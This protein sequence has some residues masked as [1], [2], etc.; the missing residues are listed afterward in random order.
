MSGCVKEGDLTAVKIYAVRTDVLSDTAGLGSG[1]V[2]VT[3]SV[4]QRRFTVV[5]V[6]H[7]ANDRAARTKI[8]GRI[9]GIV[10][11]TFLD[12]NDDLAL[13]LCTHFGCDKL[14]GIIVDRLSY[15]SHDAELHKLF[16]NLGSGLFQFCGKVADGNFIAD[17]NLNRHLFNAFKLNAAQ[18]IRLGLALRASF[19]IAL[20]RTLLYLLTVLRLSVDA[21]IVGNR[22]VFFIVAVKFD[23][24]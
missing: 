23:I 5:N 4:E 9:L 14:C 19:L 20:L 18:F 11:N 22:L 8:F 24:C 17:G 13:D 15:G 21:L 10:H 3:D 7:Y 2:F 1:D 6:T 16:N 12:S